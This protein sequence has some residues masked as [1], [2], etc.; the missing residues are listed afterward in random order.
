MQLGCL[1]T[2]ATLAPS[3]LTIVVM[4]N[5]IYQITGGAADAPPRRQPT[6]W[7]S[8]A[9]AASRRAPGPPTKTISSAWWTRALAEDGPQLIAAQIDDKPAVATTE[10]DPVEIRDRFMRGLGTR[11]AVVQ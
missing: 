2:V 9:A 1:A 6:S 3:N 7:R 10:R 11:K 4:D 8:P 5:G